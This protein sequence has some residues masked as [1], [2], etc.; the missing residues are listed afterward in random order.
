MGFSGFKRGKMIMGVRT[1]TPVELAG[2]HP[3]LGPIDLVDVRTPAEFREAHA[4]G[5]RSVPLGSL[6]PKGVMEGRVGPEGRPLYLICR[7][8]AR[9][10]QAVEAFRKGGYE[11]VVNVEGGTLAWERAGLPLVRGEKAI[12][13]ERQVRISAGSLVVVGVTL[14][15][16]VHP[17]FLA[18]A[19]FVGAGLVFSGVTDTCGM[20]MVLARMPWNQVKG[21]A[22][23]LN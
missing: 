12:S 13:L 9:S 1:I 19:G 16:F 21:A 14:G 18:L 7:S 2:L 8:G 22:V 6:D 3:N 5:A 10:R 4:E 15:A 17:G 20:G 11:D 23:P